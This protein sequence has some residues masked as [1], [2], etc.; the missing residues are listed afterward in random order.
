MMFPREPLLGRGLGTGGVREG[1]GDAGVS[2]EGGSSCGAGAPPIPI[3]FFGSRSPEPRP[4][5]SRA[6][7]RWSSPCS[8]EWRR[9]IRA[10]RPWLAGNKRKRWFVLRRPPSVRR[11]RGSSTP[12]KRISSKVCSV[13]GISAPRSQVMTHPTAQQSVARGSAPSAM[14]CTNP[15]PRRGRTRSTPLRS[16]PMQDG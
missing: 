9:A 8:L 10:W 14:S 3:G 7:V 12:S 13:A 2:G 11:A 5:F 16:N 6:L 15:P 1:R 4:S